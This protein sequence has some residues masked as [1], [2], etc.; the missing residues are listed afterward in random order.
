MQ[1]V[2]IKSKALCIGLTGV[3]A[4]LCV[5]AADAAQTRVSGAPLQTSR[6]AAPAV[7]TVVRQITPPSGL[8]DYAVPSAVVLRPGTTSE[9]VETLAVRRR[10]QPATLRTSPVI[11]IG[12]TSMNVTPVL[13]NPASLTNVAVRL[14]RVPTLAT[15][16]AQDMQVVEVD[17]GLVVTQFLSYRLQPGACSTPDNR[18]QLSR[19][20]VGC[21]T[22]QNL[23]ARTSAFADPANPRFIVDPARRAK[24]VASAESTAQAQARDIARDIVTLR[25]MLR[26]PAA[27]TRIEAEIGATETARLASLDDATLEAELVN[28]ATVEM[29]EVMFVPRA[30]QPNLVRMPGLTVPDRA[31]PTFGLHAIAPREVRKVDATQPITDH[32][33][34][35]GFT[36][37]RDYEWRK[38]V[39]VTIKWC[40]IGCKKTYYAELYAGFGYGFG[41]RF[42]IRM[43]GVYH[44]KASGDKESATFTPSFTTING[45][46]ADY[47]AAGLAGSQVFEGKELVAQVDAHAGLRFK[48]PVFG[49]GDAGLK[50]G[51]DLTD[52]LPAPY[53]RGQFTPPMP[54]THPAPVTKVFDNIDLIGGRANFGV[55]GGKILPAVK[56]DLRSDKLQFRLKDNVSGVRVAMTQPGHVYPLAIKPQDH[57]SDFTMGDPV[58]NLGF[59]LTPG[60]TARL[61][62]DVAVWGDHWDWNVWFPQLTIE[63]PPHGRD[64]SCHAGTICSRHY[65]FSATRQREAVGDMALPEDP[66]ER[67]IVLW[68]RNF[69]AR[70]QPECPDEKIRLCAVAISSLS[71]TYTNLMISDIQAA[72]RSA[73]DPMALVNRVNTIYESG[74]TQANSRAAAVIHEAQ[75]RASKRKDM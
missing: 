2:A 59:E 4:L 57:S 12:G 25:R 49:S 20:G 64:F 17:K 23:Q 39:S 3:F 44:Y 69:E 19:S 10:F 38:R 14:K 32:I 40:L 29:E 62:V 33:Y 27:R 53:A 28:T 63:L 22:R 68:G 52:G 8:Q 36:L 24:A 56:F 72:R 75:K 37:G 54:G 60:I 66:V 26:D 46:A 67:R 51:V 71:K 11:R 41:L 6:P 61:F 31:S 48:V 18:L 5:G 73:T 42:P 15:V 43:G 30:A 58:Y 70:W 65:V 21:F 13:S 7:K 16:L 55:A 50:I 9:V 74:N 47:A 45:T 1:A 34:L 35:T